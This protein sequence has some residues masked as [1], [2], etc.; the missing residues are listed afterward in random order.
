MPQMD[1]F[2]LTEKLTRIETLLQGLSA[3][4]QSHLTD[5]SDHE[6]RI[7][8]LEKDDDTDH[9]NRLRSL[10]RWRW[11]FPS[12]ALIVAVLGVVLSLLAFL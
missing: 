3:M 2:Q 7:R 8:A 12:A 10:E 6:T 1:D 4:Y 9:E 5:H 11:A